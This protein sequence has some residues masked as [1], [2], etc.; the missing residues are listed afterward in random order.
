MNKWHTR[1]LA[2]AKLVASWSKDPST[3]VGCVIVD[4][5]NQALVSIGFNGFPRGVREE[6]PLAPHLDPGRWSRPDK[7]HWVEHAER[8][9]I[10]NA[11][12]LG[13]ATQ[14]CWAYMNY[15][16]EPCADCARAFVQ[17][18]I[19]KL[20][21]NTRTFDGKGRDVHYEVST[22]AQTILHEGLVD[23]LEVTL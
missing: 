11:A 1:W 20:I 18:G 16:P 15:A 14:G 8:N 21:G 17:A 23:I 10:F 2:M 12:R 22:I 3:K 13:I 7:Y 4:P 19:T 9:A 6:A 5:H